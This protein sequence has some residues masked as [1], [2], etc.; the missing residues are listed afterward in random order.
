[1]LLE[2]HHLPYTVIM[3]QWP[4]TYCPSQYDDPIDK[5]MLNGLRRDSRNKGSDANHHIIL[6]GEMH[7]D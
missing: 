5:P 7:L 3:R 6:A 4:D 2:N 1:M